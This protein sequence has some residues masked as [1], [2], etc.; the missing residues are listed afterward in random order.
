MSVC[1]CVHVCI[2]AH[3]MHL[4]GGQRTTC[5]NQHVGPGNWTQVVSLEEN[6]FTFWAIS[7]ALKYDFLVLRDVNLITV[8][9]GSVDWV[10]PNFLTSYCI[11]CLMSPVTRTP[12]WSPAK[13]TAPE[14]VLVTSAVLTSLSFL[15]MSSYSWCLAVRLLLCYALAWELSVHKTMPKKINRSQNTH[16]Y[17]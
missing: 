4:C 6:A 3:A 15:V 8:I 14:C 16:E 1:E 11:W 7:P 5:V 17:V 2:P 12:L 10:V 13:R 9:L